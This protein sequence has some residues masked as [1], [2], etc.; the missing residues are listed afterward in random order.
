MSSGGQAWAPGVFKV[1]N[2]STWALLGDAA[3]SQDWCPCRVPEP[4]ELVLPVVLLADA[5]VALDSIRTPVV[6]ISTCSSFFNNAI[7]LDGNHRW[8]PGLWCY[9]LSFLLKASS[10][11]HNEPKRPPISHPAEH[12]KDQRGVGT[13]LRSYSECAARAQVLSIVPPSSHITMHIS[14]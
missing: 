14:H 4:L 8:V 13:C 9:I 12:S 11:C 5:H 2:R 7:V 1:S 3:V 10:I 6:S